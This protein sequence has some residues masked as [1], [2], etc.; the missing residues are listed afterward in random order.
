M[1]LNSITSLAASTLG[2]PVVLFFILGFLAALARVDLSLPQPVAKTIA[3]YL[4]LAIGFKGG[5]GLADSGTGA[6]S[7][8]PLLVGIVF[9]GLF[10][11]LAFGALRVA[12]GLGRTDAAA[13]A[14]HYGSISIVTFLTATQVLADRGEAAEGIL[15]AVAA[16]MEAPAIVAGLWLA[17]R[18]VTQAGEGAADKPSLS[19]REAVLNSSVVVLLGALAIGWFTGKDGLAD[20]K[21]FVVDPFKGVLCLFLLDMGA[22][23]GRGLLQ[24]RSA[25]DRGTVL[26]GLYMP[27]VGAALMAAAVWPLDLSPAGKALMMVLAASASYIAVPAAMRLA[28]PEAKPVI[29]TT[30]SLGITFPF[31]VVVGIPIYVAAAFALFAS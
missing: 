28:L 26:F 27:L 20:I 23:A 5:V 13:V 16:A 24:N 21:P 9:S 31:N 29:Y 18:A 17:G 7:V 15:V 3:L 11:L 25:I 14:A 10:P 19:A 8:L 12:S 2:S 30:L 22:V 1:D 4:M 6:A